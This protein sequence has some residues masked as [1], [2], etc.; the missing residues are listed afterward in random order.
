MLDMGNQNSDR[1]QGMDKYEMPESRAEDCTEPKT[2]R[3]RD[4]N[5]TSTSTA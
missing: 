4:R 1:Q 5:R 3:T 2:T